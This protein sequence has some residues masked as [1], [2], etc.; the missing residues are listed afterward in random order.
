L[1]VEEPYTGFIE[2]LYDQF[3]LDQSGGWAKKGAKPSLKTAAK[4][5]AMLSPLSPSGAGAKVHSPTKS[6]AEIEYERKYTEL[7]SPKVPP[8]IGSPTLGPR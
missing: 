1:E 4:V 3:V 6:Q 2:L 7:S 8:Q 5:A